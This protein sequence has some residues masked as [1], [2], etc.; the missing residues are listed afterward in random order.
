MYLHGT[1]YTTAALSESESMDDVETYSAG[2]ANMVEEIEKDEDIKAIFV[3]V[4]SAGG[5]PVAGEEIANAFK[6]S[7][8]EVVVLIRSIGASAAYWAVSSGDVIFAS[9]NSD[10]GGIGVQINYLDTFE[11]NQKEGINSNIISS[12]KFK[13]IGDPNRPLTEEEKALLQE[14]VDEIHKNFVNVVAENRTLEKSKVEELA[15]GTTMLGSKALSAGLIDRIGGMS[16]ARDYLKEKYGEEPK[17]CE[18]YYETAE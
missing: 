11:K 15:N 17:I 3:D 18:T 12:A 1:L 4:N 7:S 5:D 14:D 6:D 13:S 8:K 9:A 10:V 2:I 16:D